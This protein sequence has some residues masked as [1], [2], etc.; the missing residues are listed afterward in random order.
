MI[1]LRRLLC[2]LGW[3]RFCEAGPARPDRSHDEMARVRQRQQEI[4]ARLDLVLGSQVDVKT[5]RGG[6]E[7]R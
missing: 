7:A 6:Q 2:A 3:R 5:R 1:S 4:A